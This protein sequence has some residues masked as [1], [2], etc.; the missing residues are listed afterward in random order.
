MYLAYNYFW[1]PPKGLDFFCSHIPGVTLRCTPGYP[2]FSPNGL[3]IM[4]MWSPCQVEQYRPAR[5]KVNRTIVLGCGYGMVTSPHK[6]L[7]MY[8]LTMLGEYFMPKR[9]ISLVM[10][11]SLVMS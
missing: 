8:F 6:S 2:L 5:K 4:H 9:N 1:R 7:A 11:A 3:L 10:A